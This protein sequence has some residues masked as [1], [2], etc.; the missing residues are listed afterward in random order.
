MKIPRRTEV[1][2]HNPYRKKKKSNELETIDR[3]VHFYSGE[4]KQS[5]RGI[6]IIYKEEIQ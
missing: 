1:R 6:C 5:K 3:F 2:Y 4:E